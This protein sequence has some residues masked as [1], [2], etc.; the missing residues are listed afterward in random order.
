[1][2]NTFG[3]YPDVANQIKHEGETITLK[4]QQ[5]VPN[6][7]QGT[8]SWNLPTPAAGCDSES[9]IQYSGI[10]VLLH[11]EPVGPQHIPE[12][13]KF[14]TPD[15]TA[16]VDMHLGDKIED[17]LVI[18]AFYETDKKNRGED[19]TT[20]FIVND[21]QPNT[22]Y[23][24]VGYAVDSQ[25]RYHSDGV[26]AYSDK[27]GG[28]KDPNLPSYQTVTIGEG[29]LPTAGTGL[30]PG[31]IYEFELLLD[32]T[33]PKA[34][35]ARIIKFSEDGINLSTYNDLIDQINLSILLADNPPQSPVPLNQGRFYWDGEKLFRWDGYQHVEL[36]VI[37]E[38]SDPSVASVGSY[39][40][41]PSSNQLMQWSANA[42][43][44]VTYSWNLVDLTV[45]SE[46]PTQL[47][48]GDDIWFTGT[49]GY[50]WCK[51][52]WCELPTLIQQHDPVNVTYPCDCGTFWFD[53]NE[54]T[55]K[56]WSV[57]TNKWETVFAISWNEAPTNLSENTYWFNDTT[58]TLYTR[59]GSP[60]SWVE[61]P[62]FGTEQVGSPPS[63]QVIL[64]SL[65][66]SE[67]EPT[68]EFRYDTVHWYNPSNEQLKIYNES[69]TEWVDSPVLV[70]PEDPTDIKSCDLWWNTVTDQLLKWDSVNNEWDIQ[71]DFFQS[72]TDPFTPPTLELGTVWFNTTEQI[73]QRWNGAA[74]ESIEYIH[75]T[76]NPVTPNVSDAWLNPTTD[77]ISVWNGSDW[78]VIDP[79]IS[80]HDPFTIPTGT[81]WYDQTN[82]ILHQRNG[83]NWEIVHFTTQPLTPL[84][85]SHW[86]NTSTNKLM[87]WDGSMWIEE[88]P[89]AHA[90]IN[91][92]CHLQI[93]STFT[94]SNSLVQILVPE[95]S[96]SGRSL[97][98]VATGTANYG[99]E[100]VHD[101]LHWGLHKD[102]KL[103]KTTV[104]SDQFLFDFLI[105]GAHINKQQYG[106]DG[107]D[108][109][110][111][112]E[113]LGVGDDGTPDEKREL[114]DS[115]LQQLGYPVVDVELTKSQLN[116]AVDRAL[117]VLRAHSSIAYKRGFFFLNIEPKQ[118]R[119]K[120]T[121]RVAG[122][123]KIVTVMSAHRFTS[124]FLSTAHGSGVYG[125]IVL[126]H[127]YNMG[128]Y[129]LLSFHLISQYIEQLEHLFATRLTFSWDE[130]SRMLSF[131][132]AFTVKERVLLDVMVERTEQEI[133]Q[134]R[135][136]KNWIENYALAE[137]KQMIAQ[138][139]GKYAT[140]PGAGGGVSL[141]ASD[142]MN[143]AQI[144]K[145]QCMQEIDDFIVNDPENVGLHS[146]IIIG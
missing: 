58:S 1:M 46:N 129:D 99:I 40:F 32:P 63:E 31:M 104:S 102:E 71:P 25:G 67:T 117:E 24:V 73:L 28:L 123:H 118:Q 22:N 144:L 10:V 42:G 120:M 130:Y 6:M 88:T 94:G 65:V 51:T 44:P 48:G 38:D 54:S 124:A 43:S 132:S 108:Q 109:T 78:N 112:Y 75:D 33:F 77:V 125:Q 60:A 20:S 45:Y 145:E 79:I 95:D 80:Q 127:L 4:F 115:I 136:S 81:Y 122:F 91:E 26:R 41:N 84:R 19:L 27:L 62:A 50:V 96:M 82:N 69:L 61:I 126:Q 68:F 64:P 23:F 143:E 13:G 55:L 56:E 66:I 39:W 5:G 9:G 121:N 92:R 89:L 8:I 74:W 34:T 139:R 106:S 76:T 97:R 135:W 131:H 134:N 133:I 35:A 98:P 57:E 119:Y 70:W 141:N 72:A 140:L 18:G 37:V 3:A 7:G 47:T 83:L 49:Q 116:I 111:S 59:S 107:V 36:S 87:K 17:A 85:N 101:Y 12:D 21:L 100:P 2:S 52:T 146:T 103:L 113:M 29:V 30:I 128:T 15:N 93:T 114:M 90:K 16:D 142:L 137:A 105:Q 53:E 110:P 11:S 14:Y 138:I 86:F